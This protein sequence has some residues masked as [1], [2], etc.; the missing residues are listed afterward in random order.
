MRSSLITCC[1]ALAAAAMP[2]L[3][4]AENESFDTARAE[5]RREL[6]LA[7]LDSRHYWQVEYPRM[8]HDLN[9]AIRLTEAEIR[10]HKALLREYRPFSRFPVGH[11]LTAT[12]HD[13]EICLLDAQLRL[14]AL[15][16]ERNFLVRFHSDEARLYDLR[17]VEARRRV[18]ALEGGEVIEISQPE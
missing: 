15:R 2:S 10:R 4:R 9:A 3:V 6:Q 13:L 5:A 1:F 12:I 16:Q 14:D 7:K 8:R 18:I 17:I 11:P